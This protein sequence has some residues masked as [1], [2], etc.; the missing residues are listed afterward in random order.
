MIV[1]IAIVALGL[2]AAGAYFLYNRL[3]RKEEVGPNQLKDEYVANP[4]RRDRQLHSEPTKEFPNPFAAKSKW[5][6]QESTKDLLAK[7]QGEQDT[8]V[9]TPS[10]Y[11][12]M[13][14]DPDDPVTRV[15]PERSEMREVEGYQFEELYFPDGSLS[16]SLHDSPWF[17]T[18]SGSFGRD[19]APHE[20]ESYNEQAD[21]IINMCGPLPGGGEL[22]CNTFVALKRSIGRYNQKMGDVESTGIIIFTRGHM[23]FEDCLKNFLY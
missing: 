18:G 3:T 8:D 7:P 23:T 19:F 16:V 12:A 21:Q 4:P 22:C 6:P 15:K 11:E 14:F 10:E 13:Q 1:R 20:V 2:V 9:V 17:A 5:I